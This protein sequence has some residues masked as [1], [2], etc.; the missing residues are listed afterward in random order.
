MVW[1]AGHFEV[2][3]CLVE[4][5]ANIEAKDRSGETALHRAVIQSNFEI[6]ILIKFTN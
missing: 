2:T 4:N 6:F 3:K 1:N 5:G